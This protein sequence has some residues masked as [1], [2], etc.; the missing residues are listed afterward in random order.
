MM[1]T[2]DDLKKCS[3]HFVGVG[4]IGMSA[5]AQV[6]KAQG[7]MVSGSDR[8][9]DK[10]ITTDVFSKLA[11]Q[12]IAIHLQNGSG[13]N[14]NTDY[15]IVSTAI[16]EDNPDI[17]KA[18]ALNKAILKRAALLAE[19]F[20]PRYGIAIGGTNGKTTVSCMVGYILDSAG[21][22]PTIIVGGCI[23]NYAHDAFLGNAKAG[24]SNIISIEADESDGSIIYYTPRVSVITNI[25][26]D[27][28][29]IE[30]VSKMF[31]VLS[32]NTKDT[33]IINADCP[34]LKKV[35]FNHKKVL[36]YGLC[37]PAA[38]LS[39]NNIVYQPFQSRF[40][41]DGHP[42][43]INLPGS[44]NVSNALAAIAVAR[45]LHI[46]DVT[47]SV[48]LGQFKGV[49]R[50]MDLIGEVN[51]I[52]VID[53][54]AHNPEKIMAAITAVKR[55][56]KR[57]IAVFQPHGYG[58]TNFMREELINAFVRVLSPEDILF[59]PE[60]F[61]AGGT[62]RRNVSS[63]DIIMRVKESGKNALF[64]E[65]R[66]D[67]ISAVKTCARPGDAILV[68]GARDNTL[69]EFSHN[70]LHVLQNAN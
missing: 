33:L 61:Y 58:P 66:Q 41:V 5:I 50:R 35:D 19:M 16:E 37:N 42:F 68:M 31:L 1:K 36:T 14:E 62:T 12:G 54:Y 60:I 44:Y 20:N 4:G 45:S 55:G 64:V 24:T 29:T 57:A 18:R 21:L 63:S 51:G 49:Q 52:K 34:Y 65:D 59:M 67:I 40:A 56:C 6:L 28:K 9:F 47:T 17:K 22:S 27:H 3:Y 46:P 15:V 8:N 7:H 25:S 39:A 48:A 23:K 10:H 43:Q 69:T 2:Y 32:Q 38:A 70:I 11:T 53:D 30:E 26:K 13:I